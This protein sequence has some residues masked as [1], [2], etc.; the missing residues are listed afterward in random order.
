[1]EKT[2]K[3]LTKKEQAIRTYNFLLERVINAELD[4]EYFGRIAK[5]YNKDTKEYSENMQEVFKSKTTLSHQTIALEIATKLIKK[6]SE[7]K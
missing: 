2:I 1:M 6:Y 5:L 4:I 3:Q 7:Q